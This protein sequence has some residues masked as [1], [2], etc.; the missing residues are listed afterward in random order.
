M[1]LCGTPMGTGTP[2]G[3]GASAFLMNIRPT[4]DFGLLYS[5]I[6]VCTCTLPSF[7]K[8]V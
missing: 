8:K 2:K 7:V 1:S 6:L 4:D 3:I 5:D